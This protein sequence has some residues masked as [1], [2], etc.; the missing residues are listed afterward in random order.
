MKYLI[1]YN[2]SIND[3]FFTSI[4]LIEWQDLIGI[5][6][7][8]VYG[9]N[10]EELDDNEKS[11]IINWW[12]K[13]IY[14]GDTF[15]LRMDNIDPSLKVPILHIDFTI[16]N[17]DGVFY[18]TKCQDDWYAVWFKPNINNRGNHQRYKCDQMNGLFKF[19]MCI[20]FK[21]I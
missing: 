20:I 14:Y 5:D 10:K 13:S 7:D 15:S 1:N 2:E 17:I 16:K 4:T 6:E 19:I 21:R 8:L 11:K 3:K 18:F 12:N 9:S